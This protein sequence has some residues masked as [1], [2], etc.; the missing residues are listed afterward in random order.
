MSVV[1]AARRMNGR[2][3]IGW[4]CF[5]RGG[6]RPCLTISSP[7]GRDACH[8][9]IHDIIASRLNLERPF[10]SENPQRTVPVALAEL[11]DVRNSRSITHEILGRIAEVPDVAEKREAI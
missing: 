8:H 10:H 6:R 5:S 1:A 7:A 3:F 11:R 9:A 4:V 2:S